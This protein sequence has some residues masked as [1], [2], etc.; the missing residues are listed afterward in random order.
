MTISQDPG[1]AA[2]LGP[3][4]TRPQL[5][6]LR[7]LAERCGCSF[8]WPQTVG[9]ASREIER[10]KALEPISHSDRRREDKA[11]CD[12]LASGPRDA[13]R[14]RAEEI[15]GFGSSARCA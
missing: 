5:A 10:L 13:A 2:T 1:E 6:Y 7:Q 12:A 11:L 8:V 9:Q 15:V 4:P 3:M 14:I